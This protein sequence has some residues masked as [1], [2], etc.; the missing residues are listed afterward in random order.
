M[1][2]NVFIDIKV[3]QYFCCFDDDGIDKCLLLSSVVFKD[4]S[5]VA[6]VGSEAILQ[7]RFD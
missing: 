4:V 2:N 5:V 7:G 1:S 6:I 3:L